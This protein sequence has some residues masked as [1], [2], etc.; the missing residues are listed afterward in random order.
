MFDAG[1]V[2]VMKRSVLLSCALMIVVLAAGVDARLNE[3]PSFGELNGNRYP[4]VFL[5]VPISLCCGLCL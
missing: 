2:V 5:G 4:V 1:Q 3:M